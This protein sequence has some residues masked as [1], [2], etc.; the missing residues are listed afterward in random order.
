MIKTKRNKDV[1]A[2]TSCNN[3]DTKSKIIIGNKSNNI[4]IKLCRE[5]LDVLKVVVEY[6]I[7]EDTMSK[8]TIDM[9][10]NYM[11]EMLTDEKAK[12]FIKHCNRYNVNPC[13]CAWY[14]DWEDFCS[15]WCDDLGYSHTEARKLLNNEWHGNVGEFKKFSD[16]TIC[17]VSL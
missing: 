14:D 10:N 6:C 8:Y 7:D 16:D 2:C 17:R 1:E 5:C 12:L 4:N 11:P 15:E 9:I 3:I 13:I